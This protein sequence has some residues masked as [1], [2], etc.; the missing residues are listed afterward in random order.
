[1]KRK[2]VK[3]MKRIELNIKCCKECPFLKWRYGLKGYTCLQSDVIVFVRDFPIHINIHSE[4]LLPDVP[5]K[6]DKKDNDNVIK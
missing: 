1:M 2:R 6:I 4:C 3:N 5:D